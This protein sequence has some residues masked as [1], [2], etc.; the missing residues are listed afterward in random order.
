MS[1]FDADLF[2][3]TQFNESNA[4]RMAP[5]PEGTYPAMISDTKI[6]VLDSGKV[7]MD[8]VWAVDDAGVKEKTGR[9]NPT[10]RQ[11]VWIDLDP[12]GGLA[13]GDGK[14]VGLGRL[15]E[16]VA[17]NTKG[18]AWSPAMLKGRPARIKVT[19]RLDK[20]SGDVYDQVSAVS[21]L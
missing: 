19:H 1:A 5:C 16:A 9:D 21:K 8:V 3:N 17:Q 6:R 14:N 18:Q 7:I 13:F 4:T 15:R 12:N 20:D 11:T 2:M 10:V